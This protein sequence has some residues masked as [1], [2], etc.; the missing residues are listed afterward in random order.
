MCNPNPKR[1]KMEIK[2]EIRIYVACLAAYN[3][4]R[5]HGRWID[6]NQSVEGIWDEIC[7]MLTSSPCPDAE[8]YAIHDYEGFEGVRIK[9]YSGMRE[10]AAKAAFI[11]EHGRLGAELIIYYGTVE[12]A[13]EAIEDRYAGQYASLADF[14]Q[15]ITEQS[16]EIPEPLRY[17]IDYDR[18]ARDM[19][20]SDVMTIETAHDEVH[21]FWNH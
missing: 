21:V 7:L 9:E 10:V 11:A 20:I 12:D 2:P 4:G 14:A 17:Y 19:A 18:M 5:L 6:A 3:G 13:Q 8:E 15:E 16:T 1:N